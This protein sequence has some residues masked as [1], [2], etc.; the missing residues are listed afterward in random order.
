MSHVNSIYKPGYILIKK[1]PLSVIAG[2]GFGEHELVQ[3]DA[4]RTKDDKFQ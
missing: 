4:N 3:C 1:G 2:W